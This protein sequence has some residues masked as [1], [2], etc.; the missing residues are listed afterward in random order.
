MIKEV[1]THHGR[2]AGKLEDESADQ[3]IKK[4]Q[5]RVAVY[6]DA[7]NLEKSVQ[8]LGLI[9][10]THFTKEMRWQANKN[11]WNVD[12]KK[13]HRFFKENTKLSNISFYTA[14]F[15]TKS[16]E[17]FLTFLKNNG[18]RLVTKPIKT[19]LGRGRIITC[20]HCGY[21]NKIPDERKADFDVE[22]SVDAVNW[23]KHYET[24]VLFSGDSDFVYLTKFLKRHGKKI[25]VL[26]RRGHVAYELRISR[27]VDYYQD[28][29]KLK[30]QFLV[31][32]F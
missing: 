16:H 8:V 17:D 14:R 7:A 19:I 24:F 5:G 31:K 30:D 18:Y 15:G 25:V 4:I 29:W 10:P 2:T 12:Y 13:L 32:S 6:I 1:K 27:D 3:L 21:K 9:P 11:Q 28:I 23:I 26:S 20:E 22:I